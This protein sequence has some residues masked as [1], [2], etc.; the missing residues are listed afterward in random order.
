MYVEVHLI[1]HH[2]SFRSSTL[3]ALTLKESTVSDF[4]AEE[5]T[6]ARRPTESKH[7]PATS[8][9]CPS[10]FQSLEKARDRLLNPKKWSLL[11]QR[12]AAEKKIILKRRMDK[13]TM[14]IISQI[15]LCPPQ[16]RSL[17]FQA[18]GFSRGLVHI[19]ELGFLRVCMYDFT[20]GTWS[21][22][23]VVSSMSI[24]T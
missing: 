16:I 19:N 9:T 24:H 2:V 18:E 11:D 5:P 21:T 12:E 6:V 7:E 22:I 14:N 10:Y 1:L 4:R 17:L 3:F 23:T 15:H 8:D 20:V 13:S